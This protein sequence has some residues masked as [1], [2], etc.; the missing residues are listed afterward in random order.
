M[1]DLL[2]AKWC[3]FL[4]FLGSIVAVGSAWG[5]QLIGGYVPCKL[6]L[7]QRVPYYIGI[8]LALVVLGL[9]FARKSVVAAIGFVILAVLFFYGGSVGAY[10]SGAE[11]S[12][13]P[14]PTD[15]GGGA[16]SPT[17]AQN[18]LSALHSTRVVDCSIASW[19]LLGLSFAGWNVVIS[20]CLVVIALTGVA[21]SLRRK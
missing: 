21:Y 19:R 7:M 4:L 16:A 18:M 20:I 11:W 8:P 9:T 2:K 13:W 10:Q 17:S 1:S 6:C 3:A 14:G 5:F 15:C 12:F